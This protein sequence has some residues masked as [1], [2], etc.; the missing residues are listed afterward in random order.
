[1]QIV[2]GTHLGGFDR[3]LDRAVGRHQHHRQARVRFVKLADELQPSHTRQP[4]IG[5]DHIEGRVAGAA[6]TLIAP[7]SVCDG[8]ALVL[9]HLPQAGGE[10]YVIF[11][12][13]ELRVCRHLPAG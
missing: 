10:V 1:M 9:E 3:G 4:Q 11:N 2:V 6:Q 5:Q 12:K 13:Q 8:V 7:G